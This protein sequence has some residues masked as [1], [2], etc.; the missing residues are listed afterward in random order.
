M[1]TKNLFLLLLLSALSFQ[2]SKESVFNGENP[3]SNSP[4]IETMAYFSEDGY[5][6][7]SNARLIVN[8]LD[9]TVEHEF[10]YI[11]SYLDGSSEGNWGGSKIS[12]MFLLGDGRVFITSP[13][14]ITHSLMCVQDGWGIR[15]IHLW[16]LT[17]SIT[18]EADLPAEITISGMGRGS[19]IYELYWGN[20]DVYN[21]SE[22]LF[23]F[24]GIQIEGTNN[25]EGNFKLD[26]K[27][28]DEKFNL[29]VTGN[30]TLERD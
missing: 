18:Q 3:E 7:V 27:S 5:S 4:S 13:P 12:E 30:G 17:Y 14:Y 16:K 23:E 6:T 20:T 8:D 21:A 26:E 15:Y 29:S 24:K 19:H 9:A 2:C 25:F 28:P 11:T 10:Q 22:I 1:K